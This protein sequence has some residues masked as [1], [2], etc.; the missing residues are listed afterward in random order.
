VVALDSGGSVGACDQWRAA[1]S[2]ALLSRRE[3]ARPQCGAGGGRPGAVEDHLCDADDATTVPANPK[4]GIAGQR[5]TG[6]CRLLRM[7]RTASE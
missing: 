2:V 6:T 7:G 1:V 5:L 3:E 4:E